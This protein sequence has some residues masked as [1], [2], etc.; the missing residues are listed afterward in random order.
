MSVFKIA[1]DT[2]NLSEEILSEQA[3]PGKVKVAHKLNSNMERS[4]FHSSKSLN[5]QEG[6]HHRLALSVDNHLQGAENLAAKG[7]QH[8]K[9]FNGS[10]IEDLKW[11]SELGST[12]TNRKS[13]LKGEI[14]ELLKLSATMRKKKSSFA[15][16]KLN[17]AQIPLQEFHLSSEI[18]N[19]ELANQPSEGDFFTFGVGES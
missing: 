19:E 10:K 7:I 4:P 6:Q 5:M 2:E 1:T 18:S 3:T 11:E 13:S 8:R 9:S 16:G 14:S 15:S 12:L 17:R